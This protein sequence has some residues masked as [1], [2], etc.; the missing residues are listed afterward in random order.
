MIIILV[1]NSISQKKTSYV[2]K[3]L[4]ITSRAD[5]VQV[6]ITNPPP[7]KKIPQVRD[8]ALIMTS[9]FEIGIICSIVCLILVTQSEQACFQAGFDAD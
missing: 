7:P 6:F 5:F 3:Y 2:T 4:H 8:S 9:R 1:Q